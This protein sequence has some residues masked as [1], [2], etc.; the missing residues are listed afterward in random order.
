MKGNFQDSLQD[1]LV[2]IQKINEFIQ[3]MDFE[4]FREDH[5]TIYAVIRALEII[6]EASKNIPEDI[7]QQNKNIP[8]KLMIGMR[9]KLIH[10]YFGVDLTVLW[11]TVK[12]DIPPLENLVVKLLARYGKK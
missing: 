8:W 1:I 5:K 3:G 12:E 2:S 11:N 6:G 7:K 9:D 4:D 10:E